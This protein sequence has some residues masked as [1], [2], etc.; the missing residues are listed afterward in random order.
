MKSAT[1]CLTVIGLL[2]ISSVAVALEP[3][4]LYDNFQGKTLDPVKWFGGQSTDSGMVTLE[5]SRLMK[6]ETVLKS[7]ALSLSNRSYASTGSDSDHSTAAT[8]IFFSNG[9][10]IKT[11]EATVLV[12]KIQVPECNTNTYATDVRARIGGAFFNTGTPTS[13]NS[14]NDVWGQI[15]V[16]RTLDS[17]DPADTLRV[18][19]KVYRCTD[20]S[21]S[22]TTWVGSEDPQDL[23]TVK[24][25]KK[26][27]LRIT[28]DPDRNEFIF[29]KGKSE[30]FVVHCGVSDTSGP[31]GL[32]GGM[33]RL[34][35]QEFLP[36]CMSDPR[37]VGYIEASFDNVMINELPPP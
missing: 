28:W 26:V 5:T 34:E 11:I 19:A 15:T 25:N 10:N 17:E 22:T 20:D 3:L 36:N 6:N 30:E 8:R 12:K 16:G 23:G 33:K 24:L 32:N 9:S 1:I 2:L 4:A 37:P 27:K 14:T 29:Q 7:K 13:G 18:Y 35:I 31:G 21:C